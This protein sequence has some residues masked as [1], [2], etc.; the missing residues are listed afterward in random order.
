M[1][2]NLSNHPFNGSHLHIIKV[3][4][5]R[6]FPSVVSVE[7]QQ[8]LIGIALFQQI[9]P[10]IEIINISGILWQRHLVLFEIGSEFGHTFTAKASRVAGY[11]LLGIILVNMQAARSRVNHHLY[12][13]FHIGQ[14]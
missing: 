13:A 1:L 5:Q 7:S 14:E 9:F 12:I 11:M 2:G 8:I 4:I 6:D 10:I 3:P